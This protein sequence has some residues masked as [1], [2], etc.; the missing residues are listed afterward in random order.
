[1]TLPE[2]PP[3]EEL[4]DEVTLR[5]LGV[6]VVGP[7]PRRRPLSGVMLAA[8]MSGVG[9]VLEPER[10]RAA[11][12]EFDPG[13]DRFADR[14]VQFVLVPGAPKASRILLRPWL[15]AG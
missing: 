8:A 14:P 4:Y 15:R 5:R 11:M 3:L 12:V 13:H 9:E 10:R 2:P 7:V 6:T 1:M